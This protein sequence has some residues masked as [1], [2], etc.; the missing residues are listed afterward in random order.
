MHRDFGRI[1]GADV[2]ETPDLLWYT[3]PSTHSWFNGAS[4]C[5]LDSGV[6]D[7]AIEEVVR[8][9]HARGRNVLWHVGPRSR[10]VDLPRRLEAAGFEKSSAVAMVLPI[11]ALRP[12]ETDRRLVVTPA[13]SR[14]ELMDWLNAFDRAFD[15][16]P[17]GAQHP[18]LEPFAVLALDPETPTE[19][20]VGRFDGEPVSS[21]IAFQGGGAVGLYGVGTDPTFRGRGFGGAVTA[22]AIQWGKA[23]GEQFAI[24][25]ATEIGEPVYRRLGFEAIG[26]KSDFF[27]PAPSSA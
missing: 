23:R 27:L 17:R 22:A 18:A 5:S 19:L 12:S 6:V 26:E 14:S 24:L 15:M 7:G 13:R 21:S 9:V 3:T 25:H 2:H 8:E 16:E 20:F 11:D 10:P 1:P 4:R